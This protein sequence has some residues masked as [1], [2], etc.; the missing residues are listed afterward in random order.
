M[1]LRI[2]FPVVVILI[3]ALVAFSGFPTTVSG[4][5]GADPSPETLAAAVLSGSDSDPVGPPDVI[6]PER[7]RAK[8]SGA[9]LEPLAV[10]KKTLY[11]TPQDEN[12]SATVLFFYNRGAADAVV[13]LKTFDIDGSLYIDTTINVPAKELVRVCSDT[14]S[15]IS[16]TWQSPVYLNFT[17]TS[18]YARIRF[19]RT[20]RIEGYVVWNDATTYDPLQVAPTLNLRFTK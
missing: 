14:V 13:Q 15:T 18:T 17:T 6:I 20:V 2:N 1:K 3:S 12:T 7:Y 11:F 16:G 4:L 5:D 8:V 9:A 19:P 10:S